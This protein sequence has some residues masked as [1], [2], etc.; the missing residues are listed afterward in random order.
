MVIYSG[1]VIVYG[2]FT[3]LETSKKTKMFALLF[4][5]Q[6]RIAEVKKIGKRRQNG[7]ELWRPHVH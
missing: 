2:L 4:S 5:S 7:L 6:K 3:H 1:V